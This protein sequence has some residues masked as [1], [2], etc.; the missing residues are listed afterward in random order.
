MAPKRATQH[1]ELAEVKRHKSAMDEAVAEFI[2]PITFALPVEPVMAEDG[3]VYEKSAIEA[4][5]QQHKRSPSTNQAMGRKLLP[6]LQVKNM[7]R[8]MVKSGALTGDKV[9]AWN[10]KLKDEETVEMTKRQA[11]DGDPRAMVLLGDWHWH[12]TYGLPRCD[13]KAFELFEK[14]H[15]AGNPAGTCQ[16]G[17]CYIL[18]LGVL[19]SK[20]RGI[21][22]LADAA[23]RGDVA[24]TFSIGE[25]FAEGKYDCPKDKKL[26]RY[27]Y[28]KLTCM[29]ETD[30]VPQLYRLSKA[31]YEKAV[32][33]L[34]KHMA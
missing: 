9:E 18:G 30:R 33:W 16:L 3:K 26:A 29:A 34:A 13:D 10:E 23:A 12:G 7:I 27:W 25:Y 15:D 8:A 4:W 1:T 21:A 31:K 2:C 32:A 6:Q 11:E 20:V 17:K 14:A 5:L 28:S 19:K 22:L 24:A